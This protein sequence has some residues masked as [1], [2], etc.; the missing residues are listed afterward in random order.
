MASI[1]FSN[2]VQQYKEIQEE[3]DEGIRGVI[4]NANFIGGKTLAKFETEFAKWCGTKFAIGTSSGTT[5]LHLALLA[6]GVGTGN[7]VITSP[8]TFIATAEAITHCGAKPVFCDIDLSTYNLDPAKIEAAITRRTKA[9]LP[10]HLYGLPCDMDAL[11]EIARKHNLMVIE[12]AAQ[13]HGAQCKGR[14]VGTF[15]DAAAFSFYPGKNLGAYGDAGAIVTD[16]EQIAGGCRMLRNHGR[17]EKYVH[18]TV[19]FNFR[20]DAIQAAILSAKLPHLKEWVARRQH[21]A[22]IYEQEI[23]T[24]AVIKPVRPHLC[25]PA[26]HLYVIRA[27]WRD[28]LASYLG[29]RGIATGIHYPVPLHLQPAYGRLGYKRSDFPYAERAASEVLSLPIYPELTDEQVRLIAQTV[30]EFFSTA[31]PNKK[32]ERLYAAPR[33]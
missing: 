12:D 11:M 26:Y 8:F 24:P 22:R 31:L 14:R 20:M 21:I 30:N 16:D 15:G 28:G 9:I 10:V 18:E 19:G 32:G 13:A 2:L 23:T 33:S 25:F 5:A 7:E 17:R 3:I 29:Q 27:P 1:P 6:C 4:S